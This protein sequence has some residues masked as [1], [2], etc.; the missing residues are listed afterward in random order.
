LYKHCKSL[1]GNYK[2]IKDINNLVDFVNNGEDLFCFE[3]HFNNWTTAKRNYPIYA[4]RYEA[5]WDNLDK[6]HEY[7]GIP[8][9]KISFFPKKIKRSS[10]LES[11]PDAEREGLLNIYSNLRDKIESY[12]PVFQVC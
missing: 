2:K 4:I 10:N 11:I 1:G 5:L 9:E 6:L 8:K 12:P 7:I 3:G